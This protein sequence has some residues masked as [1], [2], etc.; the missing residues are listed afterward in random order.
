MLTEERSRKKVVAVE[1]SNAR[2]RDSPLGGGGV[3]GGTG[4]KETEK[5]ASGGHPH[6]P[7]DFI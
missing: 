1:E 5:N 3:D 6:F 2:R 7:G 4:E